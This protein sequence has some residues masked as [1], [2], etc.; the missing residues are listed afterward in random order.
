MP[1]R[2]GV[3]H[4]VMRVLALAPGEIAAMVRS[5]AAV[6]DLAASPEGHNV[7][8]DTATAHI[9]FRVLPGEPF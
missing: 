7:V 1:D 6:V 5:T 3:R 9:N 8:P 2:R 4:L